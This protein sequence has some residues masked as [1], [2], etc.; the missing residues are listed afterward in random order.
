MNKR[1]HEERV[2]ERAE[3]VGEKGRPRKVGEEHIGKELEEDNEEVNMT[4]EV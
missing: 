4:Q 2:E 1:K 3:E